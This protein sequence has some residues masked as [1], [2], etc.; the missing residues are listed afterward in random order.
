MVN[1]CVKKDVSFQVTD[2]LVHFDN[3]AIILIALDAQRIDVRIE[4]VPLTGPV[5][6]YRFTSMD[7]PALHSV[8][9]FH[10]GMHACQDG[11]DTPFVEVAISPSE[12]FT[13]VNFPVVGHL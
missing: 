9:P 12:E 10:C 7:V 2:N 4:N 5:V 13:V 3:H 1:D 6:A 11:I 8:C